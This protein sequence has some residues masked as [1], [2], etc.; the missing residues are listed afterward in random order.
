MKPLVSVI[1]PI[2]NA[3]AFIVETLDSILASSYR[4]I[5][6][7]MVDDGSSDDSLSIASTYCKD[8]E[9]CYVYKQENAGVSAARNHAIRKARGVYI[10]PV[11]ADDKIGS[12][13]IE[14]AVQ[15]LENDPNIRVVGCHARMFDGI[16]KEWKLPTFSHA[17]LARK[18]MIPVSS[19]FR[20]KDWEACGGFCEEDIYREDWDF[21]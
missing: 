8:H 1:V 14:H 19:M 3:A 11:D 13:Y 18:N 17:L 20:K 10:L 21:G 2:Y 12:T 5:E 7:V 4:P 15:I 9:E 6:V 16:D